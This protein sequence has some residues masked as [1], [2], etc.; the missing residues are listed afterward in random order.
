MVGRRERRRLDRRRRGR[1]R[2][3]T[4][5][6]T[7]G[8]R[9]RGW[10]RPR[11]LRRPHRVDGGG[12]VGLLDTVAQRVEGDGQRR[13]WADVVELGQCHAPPQRSSRPVGGRRQGRRQRSPALVL[14]RRRCRCRRVEAQPV[15]AAQPRAARRPA[16]VRVRHVTLQW[17]CRVRQPYRP[18]RVQD[19]GGRNGPA[20]PQQ[21]EH[22]TPLRARD[23]H[24]LVTDEQAQ[25]AETTRT[26]GVTALVAVPT[27]LMPFILAAASFKRRARSW[28]D[29]GPYDI[30]RHHSPTDTARRTGDERRCAALR[31]EVIDRDHAAYDE[32]RRVWNGL[33]DRRA[34]IARCADV[35]D[36]VGRPSRTAPSPR[37]EHRGGGHQVA[38]SAVCDDGLVI[39]LSAMRAVHVNA[40]ARTARAGA[41]ATWGEVDRATQVHGWPPRRRGVGH[42]RGRPHP[43]RRT[44]RDDAHHGLSRPALG[45][46]R[47]RRRHGPHRQPRAHRPVLGRPQAAVSAWSPHW[48]SITA[49]GPDAAALVLS[50][51]AVPV[52]RAWRD[53]A[54][55]AP[56]TL[57]PEIGLWSIPRCPTSPPRCTALGRH[58]RR[59]LHR[60]GPPRRGPSSPR[61][62]S[63]APRSP[64]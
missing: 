12:G 32:A 24:H 30:H 54:R 59:R 5:V 26:A 44:R 31:G 51:D 62:S 45:R 16:Q 40:T 13:Q 17:P 55:R 48:S 60:T 38:G 50:D 9:R 21:G 42:R 41:G 36:V 11:R 8:Q 7:S 25:R 61:C 34:V 56:D 63:S 47:H 53:A 57:A 64:T 28:G 4:S 15:G 1:I 35:A 33:I 14:G 10:R 29:P 18:Q 23:V 46:D 6:P 58:G 2:I 39:D 19:V 3:N 20:L 37:H 52:L 22:G 43:R 27:A 49:L